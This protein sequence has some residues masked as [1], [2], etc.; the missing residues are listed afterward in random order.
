MHAIRI[1]TRYE[2]WKPP[3][4]S[5]TPQTQGAVGSRV[6][7][8][9]ELWVSVLNLESVKKSQDIIF[10]PEPLQWRAIEVAV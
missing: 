9:S 6:V 4:F 3:S 7:T 10:V 2:E 8:V 1:E 5:T